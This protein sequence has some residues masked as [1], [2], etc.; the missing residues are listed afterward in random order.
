MLCTNK[1]ERYMPPA[2]NIP[3]INVVHRK[4]ILSVSIPD[5]VDNRN[6]VPI[7]REPTNA[8]TNKTKINIF[9]F[10]EMVGPRRTL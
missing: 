8:K 4:P 6:V 2:A 1:D 3:P 7:V 9:L 10:F 5:T